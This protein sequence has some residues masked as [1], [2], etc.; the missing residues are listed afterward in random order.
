MGDEKRLTVL[1]VGYLGLT[2][3]ACMANLGFEVMA[4][5]NDANKILRL[6]SGHMP[7]HEPGLSE[8]VETG[9]RNGNL[10]FSTS[11]A[12]AAAFGDIHFICTGTPADPGSDRAD[13]SQVNACIAELTPLL[14]RECL[15]VGK[16]TVP[17]GT[18]RRL[19]SEIRLAPGDVELAWNPE[20]LREGSAV[21]DTLTPDRIVLGVTSTR[22]EP[23]LRHVYAKQLATGTQLFV[24]D[25][26]TAELAKIAANSFLATKISFIN[27]MS[28]ICDAAGGDVVALSQI[29]GA[30]PRIGSAFLRAGL[31]FGGGCLPKDIRAFMVRADELGVGHALAFLREVQTIN[32]RMRTKTVDLATHLAG[33]S[34][35]G[36]PVC[37]LGAAF[38]PRSDDVRDS[39]ALDVAQI[40][41]GLGA[42]VTVYDPAATSR[43]REIYPELTYTDSVVAAARGAAI[44]L[45][46]TEWPEFTALQPE[47]LGALVA[48]RR[49]VD[50]RNVLDP[51]RWRA[52]GWKYRALGTANLPAA[53]DVEAEHC[54][55]SLNLTL[56]S[57]NSIR[58][59]SA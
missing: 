16:S 18:A 51:A 4:V 36:T 44:V 31:G 47:K 49:I 50:G 21:A 57:I 15:V 46:L 24:A 3:A 20:F 55:R 10:R 17:V 42:Q 6:N 11:Y 12:A 14:R 59:D 32:L 1:G 38:K 22:A 40:I 13:L 41:H 29:L 53:D 9:L 37:V 28:E 34:L 48:E 39:P 58:R 27:A 5:D 25:L 45:L 30:D 8:L 54:Q 26:E 43:A 19:A 52:A 33:G 2:H 23:A 7:I 56:A 35:V